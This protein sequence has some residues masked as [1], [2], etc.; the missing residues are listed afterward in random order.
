LLYT[1]TG[2]ASGTISGTSFTSA[3]FTVSFTEN[4]TSITSPASGY[5]EY[6]GISGSFNEGAFTATLTATTLE[7]NGNAST[8]VGNFEDVF[9][10]NSDFLRERLFAIASGPP[11]PANRRCR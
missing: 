6:S 11:R 1:F 5:Y 8:G 10:F 9:L 3:P 4:T 2:V 7:V